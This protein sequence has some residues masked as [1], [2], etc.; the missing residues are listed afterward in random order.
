[1]TD[2]PIHPTSCGDH[3]L[4]AEPRDGRLILS[5]DIEIFASLSAG[6]LPATKELKAN[7]DAA[8]TYRL[9]LL[10]QLAAGQRFEIVVK[11]ALAYKQS[12]YRGKMRNRNSL[13]FSGKHEALATLA[14]TW[15]N[16]PFLVDHNKRE[17]SARKGTILTSEL[18]EFQGSP[19]FYMGFSVVKPDAVQSVLD[20]TLDR[21]SIGWNPAGAVICTVHDVNVRTKDSCYCWPGDEVQYKGELRTVEYEY[22]DAEGE[23][24]SGVNIPAVKSTKIEDYRAALAAE[25]NLPRR[26]QV[27]V[28]RT[29]ENP[30]KY[31]RLAAALAL[32]ALD[33]PQE[34][35]ALAAVNGL[36]NRA[37][38]AEQERDTARAQLT[39]AQAELTAAKAAVAIAGATRLD[40]MIGEAI[41]VGKIPVTRDAQGQPQASAMERRLRKIGLEPGGLSQ[42]E[43][44]LAELPTIVPTLASTPPQALITPPPPKELAPAPAE[45]GKLT[46]EQIEAHNPTF[47]AALR[48]H[49]AGAGIPLDKM[50]DFMQKG[51]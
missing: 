23:E 46:I 15:K 2:A 13:R 8:N 42:V 20:G 32:S 7:D 22:H 31:A 44:E 16:Q 34:D 41:R 9:E 6:A 39:A 28:P 45:A 5:S 35:A 33:E 29:E 48:A 3:H 50:I 17:Q 10:R 12:V 37:A 30:M 40:A 51:A 27:S 11:R 21:F 18:G 4:L 14:A 43:Q 38:S 19:A 26:V 1:M 49:A 36:R 47:A 25:L 24:L